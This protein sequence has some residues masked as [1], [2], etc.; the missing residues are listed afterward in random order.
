MAFNRDGKLRILIEPARLAL[1]YLPGF[2]GEICT[3]GCEIYNIAD[4]DGKFSRRAR[5]DRAALTVSDTLAHLLGHLIGA[6]GEA[7]YEGNQNQ[8]P[9][10]WRV[11]LVLKNHL[12]SLKLGPMPSTAYL[13][14]N[15]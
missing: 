2:G 14:N 15:D 7:E 12:L 13:L 3:I 4:F 8:N 5:Q 6:A 9:G 10:E 11:D 1:Q